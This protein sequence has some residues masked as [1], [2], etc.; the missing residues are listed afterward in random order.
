MWDSIKFATLGISPLEILAVYDSEGNELDYVKNAYGLESKGGVAIYKIAYSY[1]PENYGL[2][3]TIGKFMKPVSY[4]L[5][6]YGVAAEFCLTQARFD[7]A[8]MWNDRF[9]KGVNA[10]M[11]PKN[12]R[13][14]G[15][16][17]IWLN[18]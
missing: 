3:D 12:G 15:R 2:T 6:A 7:E 9:V 1:L 13:V 8:L 16:S 17:F 14:K 11:R 10:L 4:N 5:L 18:V